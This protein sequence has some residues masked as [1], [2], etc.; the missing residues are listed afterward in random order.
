[1]DRV[2][3]YRR[4]AAECRRL[5]EAVKND[6]NRAILLDMAVSWEMLAEELELTKHVGQLRESDR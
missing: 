4:Y 5:A 3:E 2:D 6:E 1:M